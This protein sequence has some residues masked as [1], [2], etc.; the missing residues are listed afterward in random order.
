[1][2]RVCHA[3]SSSLETIIFMYHNK[4]IKQK[5]GSVPGGDIVN[6][7]PESK[8]VWNVC[9]VG[10][11]MRLFFYKGLGEFCAT[12]KRRS[13]QESFSNLIFHRQSVIFTQTN[14]NVDRLIDPW[15]DLFRLSVPSQITSL[16]G[17]AE[18]H[19]IKSLSQFTNNFFRHQNEN[20][21]R[22][23]KNEMLLMR[24]GHEAEGL[25]IP[26]T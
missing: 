24:A 14:V 13:S 7:L 16:K 3:W 26:F 4:A 22:T 21:H 17:S 1:M 2:H 19:F 15:K 8:V 6:N 20:R 11:V 10:L 12:I 5:D 18:S 25:T 9:A 23:V